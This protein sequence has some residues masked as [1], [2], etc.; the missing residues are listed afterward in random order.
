MRAI[1]ALFLFAGVASAAP[2]KFVVENKCQKF[3]VENKCQAK[4]LCWC[5]TTGECTCWNSQCGC[6]ACGRGAALE[7]K[8]PLSD[9]TAIIGARTVL[10]SPQQGAALGSSAAIQSGATSTVVSGAAKSGFT[11]GCE[12]G[13]CPSGRTYSRGLIRWR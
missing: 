10:T 1:V 7:V 3:T 2:Q 13:N 6:Q 9:T 4:T 12:S 5:A 11:S 8:K